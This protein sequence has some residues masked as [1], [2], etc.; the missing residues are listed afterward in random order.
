MSIICINGENNLYFKFKEFDTTGNII[1]ED[2]SDNHSII[3]ILNPLQ[4]VEGVVVR[5]TQTH[6]FYNKN[7]SESN[8]YQVFEKEHGNRI[9]WV[10]PLQALTSQEHDYALNKYFLS[11][12]HSAFYDLFSDDNLSTTSR[13]IAYR[14]E[15]IYELEDF[16]DVEQV[17]ILVLSV[18][19]INEI[20]NFDVNHYF[21]D[22]YRKGYFLKEYNG[23]KQVDE[24]DG[25]LKVCS[26]SKDLKDDDYPFQLFSDV[27]ISETH[28][29]VKFHLLYQ[30]I[31]LMIEKIFDKELQSIIESLNQG[32][33][34]LSHIK[35]D[36]SE[37]SKEGNRIIKLFHSY[38][39]NSSMKEELMEACNSL[40]L[41]NEMKKRPNSGL[42]LYNVRNLIVHD[43]RSIP[44]S[45][46]DKITDINQLFEEVVI[47]ILINFKNFS[48]ELS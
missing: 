15:G 13:K 31:E 44:L 29:L 14:E 30:V 9:G 23:E 3:E 37:L 40:L 24:V 35:D 48:R 6:I 11:Y 41:S 22:F 7:F 25:K 18:Q 2:I 12:A 21:F 26:V 43:Y 20:P 1:L 45:D 17:H 34:K 46:Y 4:L 38:T 47:D 19:S 39:N 32:E 5:K 16:Y 28:Q 10:F 36:F 27:L 8:I 42:A 33:R